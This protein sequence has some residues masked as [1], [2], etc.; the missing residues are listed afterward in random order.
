L[1]PLI[2]IIC[3]VLAVLL[4]LKNM[5]QLLIYLPQDKHQ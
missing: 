5:D 1:C 2:A 3:L 4:Q